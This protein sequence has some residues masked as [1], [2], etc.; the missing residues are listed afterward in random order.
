MSGKGHRYL[1]KSNNETKLDLASHSVIRFTCY[2]GYFSKQSA[3]IL[4]KGCACEYQ[5]VTCLLLNLRARPFR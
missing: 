4:E 5:R 1:K 2:F 3:N